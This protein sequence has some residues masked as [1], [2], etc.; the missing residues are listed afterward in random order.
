MKTK[1]FIPGL[2]IAIALLTFSCT[3]DDYETPKT[4][5]SQSKNLHEK[6]DP[7]TNKMVNGTTN[8]NTDL[9]NTEGDPEITRP[10]RKD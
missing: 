1:L 5:S 3:N 2:L 10:T 8:S 9:L 4:Q 7:K 6:L